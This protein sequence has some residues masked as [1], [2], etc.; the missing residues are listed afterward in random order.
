MKVDKVLNDIEKALEQHKKEKS[1]EPKFI[2]IDSERA[3]VLKEAYLSLPTK[4]FYIDILHED[5]VLIIEKAM[6][7]YGEE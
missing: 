4:I 7:T 6:E 5:E 3:E 2:I 1:T